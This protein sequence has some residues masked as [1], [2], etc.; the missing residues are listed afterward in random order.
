VKKNA[1]QQYLNEGGIKCPY[2]KSENL[3]SYAVLTTTEPLLMHHKV[4]CL[5]CNK[6]WLDVYT[7][8]DILTEN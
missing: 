2:C 5:S 8:T 6:T 1:K 7:L 4:T 3:K